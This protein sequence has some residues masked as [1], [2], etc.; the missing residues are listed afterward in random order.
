MREIKL[1]NIKIVYYHPFR[2]NIFSTERKW[3]IKCRHYQIFILT[4][5]LRQTL[6]NENHINCL[7]S[8]LSVAP[9][10]LKDKIEV[11]ITIIEL[12]KSKERKMPRSKTW[13]LE[14]EKKEPVVVQLLVKD[15][16]CSRHVNLWNTNKTGYKQMWIPPQS[17]CPTALLKVVEVS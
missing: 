13:K 4:L 10:I 14:G 3:E 2:Q 7:E 11:K 15:T 16:L 1:F 12:L 8:Q 6:F 17:L 9:S 5:S